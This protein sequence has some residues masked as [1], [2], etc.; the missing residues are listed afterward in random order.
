MTQPAWFDDLIATYDA[1]A[2]EREAKG[3]PEW[4]NP[5]REAFV[6]RVPAAGRILEIGAGVGYSSRWFADRG[7]DVLAT[8]LSAANVAKCRAKGVEAVVRDMRDLDL[9]AESFDGVWAASCLLHIADA[10]LPGVLDGIAAVMRPG[11]WFWAGT[12]GGSDREGVWEQDWYEPKRF[13]SNRSDDRIRRFYEGT[14]VV[15]SF[16]VID[17][18]PDI[19]WHYQMALMRKPMPEPAD[20]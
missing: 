16:E 2:E 17:P 11:G 1:H 14:F 7:F 5:V 13:Y 4:R 15:E 3:E 9:P 8:D 6:A 20:G 10:D 19:E 18:E 12:W